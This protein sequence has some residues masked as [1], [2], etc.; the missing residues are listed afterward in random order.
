VRGREVH[1]GE[2]LAAAERAL[3]VLALHTRT[4]L[5]RP[6]L[7]PLLRPLCQ[8]LRLLRPRLRLL[9]PLCPRLRLLRPRLRLLLLRLS[10][11]LPPCCNA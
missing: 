2:N 9:L 7:R 5:L 3:Q 8:R 6:R 1:F 11:M 4:G 10:S